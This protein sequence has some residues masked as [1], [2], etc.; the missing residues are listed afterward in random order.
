MLNIQLTNYA[1]LVLEAELQ[2]VQSLL[3][4]IIVLEEEK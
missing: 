3:G 2:K 4:V 1:L